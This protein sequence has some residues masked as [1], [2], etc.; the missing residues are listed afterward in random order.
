MSKIIDWAMDAL[1]LSDGIDDEGME[2]VGVEKEKTEKKQAQEE[3]V[4]L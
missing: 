1:G 3:E 2:D 4:A